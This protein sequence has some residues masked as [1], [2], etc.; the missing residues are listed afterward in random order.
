M[1]RAILAGQ[2]TQTRRVVKL[3]HGRHICGEPEQDGTL[4]WRPIDRG[5]G[6][7]IKQTLRLMLGECPYGAPGDRLWVRETFALTPAVDAGAPQK[8]LYRADPIYDGIDLRGWRW[9]PAIHMPRRYS[10]LTLEITDVR[11]QRL[12]DISEADAIAEGVDAVSMA[13]MPRQA[14][15]NR[16]TDFAHIWDKINGKR[17]PWASNP[18]VWA[19][20]FE[21][22]DA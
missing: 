6:V 12:Q 15:L 4:E 19:L 21:R 17:A 13:D 1:V 9:S 22:V 7:V 2:K 18:W 20:T 14:T 8:T 16:R 10:R 11:V 5:D 3:P